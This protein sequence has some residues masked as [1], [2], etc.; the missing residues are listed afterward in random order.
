MERET[1]LTEICSPEDLPE[2]IRKRLESSPGSV[3]P[4]LDRQWILLEGKVLSF[5][6]DKTGREIAIAIA[7]RK[8]AALHHPANSAELY[9]R[10]LTDDRYQPPPDLLRKYG[11]RFGRKR[12]AAVFRAC[13]PLDRDL[14]TVIETMTP[15]EKE[16]AVIPI[17]YQTAAYIK[18]LEGQSADDMAEFTEA[19]IGTLETEGFLD[20][21]AGVGCESQSQEELRESFS[22]A[23][24]A[25]TLGMRYHRLDRV[26]LYE[27]Q[28]L[29]RIIDTIPEEKKKEIRHAFYGDSPETA[30][31]DEMLETVRVFF[32][33]DLNLTAASKQLFIHRNTLNYRLDKIKKEFGLD[34][35]S[36]GDAVVFRIISE[37]TEES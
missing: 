28:M 36:F 16:D 22:E 25:L 14:L 7:G 19:V 12:C 30:L 34:L 35:R 32:R 29:E 23:K 4:Y 11:I 3:F 13:S 8:A 10:I 17:D 18:D 15:V 6:D 27:R 5:P 21:R 9:E 2:D 37:I 33:N 26:Y 1:L 31:S 20:I 24:K